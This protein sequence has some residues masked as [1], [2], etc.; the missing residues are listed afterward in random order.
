MVRGYSLVFKKKKKKVHEI[1]SAS[2]YANKRDV[3][4]WKK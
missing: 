1:E 2:E 3:L 4:L